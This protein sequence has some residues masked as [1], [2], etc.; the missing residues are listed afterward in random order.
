MYVVALKSPYFLRL[1]YFLPNFRV[2]K[3]FDMGYYW[4]LCKWL[5]L[6]MKLNTSKDFQKHIT[7]IRDHRCGLNIRLLPLGT[8][9]VAWWI[10]EL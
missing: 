10:K 4:E 6:L 1:D 2:F 5:E 7:F 8:N 3:K 9:F